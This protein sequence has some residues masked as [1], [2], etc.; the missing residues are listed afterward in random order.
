MFTIEEIKEL[1]KMVDN[2][3][4]QRFEIKQAGTKIML[5]KGQTTVNETP[6]R[7]TKQE[8]PDKKAEVHI[9]ASSVQTEFYTVVSPV[10]G[11]FYAASEPGAEPFVKAGDKV[12][13]DKVVC[14]VEVMKLFNEIE[15]GVAGEIAEVLVKDGEFVEY[16]QPLFLIR[17]EA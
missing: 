7:H 16:G 9:E 4:L 2:S 3:S 8:I 5:E 6:V 13:A 17:P 14:I 1:I 10:V 15:A 11:M 12:A